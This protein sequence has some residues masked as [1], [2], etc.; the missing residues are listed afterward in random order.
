MS[1]RHVE[2]CPMNRTSELFVLRTGEVRRKAR[3]KLTTIASWTEHI[4]WWFI[5]T[6]SEFSWGKHNSKQTPRKRPK[7]IS[8]F[9]TP[10]NYL[11][12]EARMAINQL[13]YRI[14]IWRS[15]VGPSAR[16]NLR[17]VAMKTL[18]AYQVG[19]ILRSSWS[20]K[21]RLAHVSWDVLGKGHLR[22]WYDRK[23][24]R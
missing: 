10:P 18:I 13:T 16:I 24:N 9:I 21:T 15:I 14:I 11:N 17:Q 22:Y 23:A 19:I 20:A 1:K 12:H 8:W 7:I 2:K 4:S 3:E 6:C 5:T